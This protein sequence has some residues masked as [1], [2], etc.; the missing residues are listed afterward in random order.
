M[1]PVVF[2]HAGLSLFAGGFV[3]VDVFFVISGFLITGILL[4]EIENGNFSLLGFYERRARR[5]LPALFLVVFLCILAAWFTW[6]PMQYRG[7]GTATIATRLFASNILFWRNASDYFAPDVLREPLLHTW[8]LAV[9]EQFYLF[10]PLLLWA[11]VGLARRHLTIVIGSLVG[12]SFLYAVWATHYTP[13]AAFYLIPARIWELGM[14]A[15]LALGAF[16]AVHRRIVAEAI[17]GAG[18]IAIALAVLLLDE[19]VRFPGAAALPP[20]LG[21]T[22]IIW[23]GGDHRTLVGRSLTWQQMPLAPTIEDYRKRNAKAEAILHRLASRY[24]ATYVSLGT[25]FCTPDCWIIDNATGHLLYSDDNHL[26]EDGSRLMVPRIFDA[27][28]E[29]FP[30]DL[31]HRNN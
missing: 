17:S 27:A 8:S 1:L 29:S 9:E 2:G 31:F 30:R 10:F 21:A 22:A 18:L 25:T 3:G 7:L 28:L 14:G 16:P 5:I 4:R 20:V 12:A 15:L 19:S 24:D 11:L 6:P 26:S 13:V 23:A